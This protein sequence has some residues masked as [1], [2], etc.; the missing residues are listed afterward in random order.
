MTTRAVATR[1]GQPTEHLELSAAEEAARQAESDANALSG[2]RAQRRHEIITEG[3]LR[4]AVQVPE[5]DSLER[6]ALLASIWNMLG[7]P[8]VAQ[9]L[10]RDLYHYVKNTALPKLGPMTLAELQAVDPSAADPFGD[11]T[12][13][14]T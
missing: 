9:A 1:P 10:A 3:V 2:L 11:G 6:V 13:W 5:W 12:P 4:I 7:A 14:P 8:N